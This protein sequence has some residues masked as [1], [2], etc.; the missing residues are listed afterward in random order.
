[1]PKQG[2]EPCR[3]FLP[4]W[5]LAGVD[6]RTPVLLAL[7]GGADSRVLLD[8][9]AKAAKR[10][11]FPL[12]LAHVDHGIRGEEAARDREFC[13]ALAEQYG[14]RLMILEAD[15]PAL[16]AQNRR[17][18]E[19]Q[20]R[21]VRYAYFAELMENEQIPLL[22]TAHHAD[23]N[24]ETVLFRLARGTR[25]RGLCGIAPVR[26]F[27]AG[28]LVRPLLHCTR[29][30]ILDYCRAHAL[31]YVTDSTN[32][33]TA[34][35]RNRIRAEVLPILEELFEGA[36]AR[37]ADMTEALREDEDY[38][39]SLA[40]DFLQKSRAGGGLAAEPL[41]QVA[42]SIRK[43]VLRLWLQE[44]LGVEP[45]AVHLQSL[46]RLLEDPS[47][48]RVALPSGAEAICERGVLSLLGE[49]DAGKSFCVPVTPG[50]ELLLPS[51]IVARLDSGAQYRKIHN[52]S[53]QTCINSSIV[54]DII[55]QD[56]YWRSRQEG[57]VI[58]MGGMHRKLRRL[59]REA[60]IPPRLRDRLPL[61]CDR[62]GI[63][64]VPFVGAR[65]GLP[66]SGT[67]YTATVR[68]PNG[69]EESNRK[70]N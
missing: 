25:L 45:E 68:L 39:T 34:Y 29:E 65:D 19:E 52:L 37:V 36:S 27:A 23:D 48:V 32:T 61:L 13:R 5:Q 42:A 8:L 7:S 28:Q 2:T 12:T 38:L 18:L 15:I 56:C 41:K 24:L 46:C 53:T 67:P 63:L 14:C 64:W 59:L 50:E 33:D 44:A 4:P 66:R 1:M 21:Q 3:G 22:A 16:A 69:A 58:L 47:G 31:A 30:E 6:P 26:A 17:G 57:D 70:G 20:A 11:G 40:E 60:G 51:G 9:L 54:F 10:D 35:A 55:E 62:E 49:E 43:R